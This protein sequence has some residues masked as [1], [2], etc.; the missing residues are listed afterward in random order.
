MLVISVASSL[1]GMWLRTPAIRLLFERGSFTPDS[2]RLVAAVFLGFVPSIV[3][4]ALMDLISRCFFAL[5]RPKMPLAA[6]AIPVSINLAIM[7]VMGRIGDPVYLGLGASAGLLAGSLALFIATHPRRRK[8]GLESLT[9]PVEAAR[10]AA[11]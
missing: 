6:A 11:R 7:S 2:T 4:W 3:G 5:D 8:P 1:A 9:E 10:T